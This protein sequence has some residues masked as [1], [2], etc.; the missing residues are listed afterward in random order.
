M[1]SAKLGLS[2]SALEAEGK[3]M[4]LTQQNVWSKGYKQVIFEGDFQVLVDT[5]RGK[6]QDISI[7]NFCK[8]L[9]L[10]ASSTSVETLC[11][12]QYILF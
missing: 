4:L 8:D 7:N 9:N 11:V 1:G 10:W 3:A 5:I 2:I 12:F 6:Q